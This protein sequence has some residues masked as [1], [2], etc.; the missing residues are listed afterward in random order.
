MTV[1]IWTR[2]AA[3]SASSETSASDSSTRSWRSLHDASIPNASRIDATMTIASVSSLLR[4]TRPPT[5]SFGADKL[6]AY[7]LSVLTSRE[8]PARPA[9]E[10]AKRT[11]YFLRNSSTS[12]LDRVQWRPNS[13]EIMA[14]KSAFASAATPALTRLL[15]LIARV[16][17]NWNAILLSLWISDQGETR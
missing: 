17:F 15:A 4:R 12:M 10:Q 9:R 5:L 16:A 14:R 6:T 3:N 11:S 13:A 1:S 8:S 7:G 2:F